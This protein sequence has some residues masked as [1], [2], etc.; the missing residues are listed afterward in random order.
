MVTYKYDAWGNW[1]NKSSASNGTSLGDTLVIINPFIS[2]GY[3]YDKETDWYYLKSRYYCP[4]LSRFI[5]MDSTNYLQP[6]QIDGINLFAYC[7][8]DPVLGY[9]PNGNFSFKKLWRSI[10]K[11]AKKIVNKIV[12]HFLE[13]IKPKR[14]YGF[15]FFETQFSVGEIDKLW[16]ASCENGVCT[17]NM[18][19]ILNLFGVDST[20]NFSLGLTSENG[21]YF[22][23][24]HSYETANGVVTTT[25]GQRIVPYAFAYATVKAYN[26]A[27]NAYN[28]VKEKVKSVDWGVIG[29]KVLIGVGIVAGVALV[30]FGGWLVITAFSTAIP[31]LI[32]LAG[33]SAA[34]LLY[35][36]L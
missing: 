31:L 1:I 34:V 10:K 32:N 20:V 21:F 12:N 22:G 19:S 3:Y 7:G 25:W 15:G 6:G 2:K 16:D 30:A 5:N 8:N 18:P 35:L 9:D 33:V 28:Y 29:R 14:D 17:I 13:K 23:I 26:Y 24:G 27:A 4:K 36:N 11:G